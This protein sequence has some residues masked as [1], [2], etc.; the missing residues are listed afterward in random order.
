MAND[1][2]MVGVSGASSRTKNINALLDVNY[3]IQQAMEYTVKY[4]VINHFVC[5]RL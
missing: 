2:S 3:L 5:I 1:D 4:F